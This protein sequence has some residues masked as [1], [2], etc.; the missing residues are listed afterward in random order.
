MHQAVDQT[1]RA[2]TRGHMPAT[3][4][5]VAHRIVVAR[6]RGASAG[7]ASARN[8]VRTNVAASQQSDG[9]APVTLSVDALAGLMRF[10][11]LG[12]KLKTIARSCQAAR[13]RI[14][15]RAL[16]RPAPST[17]YADLV[18]SATFDDDVP[19][20]AR[21]VD[22]EFELVPIPITASPHLTNAPPSTAIVLL[23]ADVAIGWAA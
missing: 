9:A 5:D 2:M 18:A 14:S 15:E 16:H 13:A 23:N 6:L 12:E 4:H 22:A 19:W 7:F 11:D 8:T 10:I 17:W 20:Y 21:E 1:R 3:A